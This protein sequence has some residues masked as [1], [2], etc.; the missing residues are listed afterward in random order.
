M[1]LRKQ[2]ILTGEWHTRE[3]PI[4]PDH[5]EAWIEQG[6][7]RPHVQHEFPHLSADDREF[8]ITGITPEEWDAA[9]PPEDE[10]GEGE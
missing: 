7:T 4:T 3:I 1:R 6:V 8:L 9:M 2:S 10:K 5:Y